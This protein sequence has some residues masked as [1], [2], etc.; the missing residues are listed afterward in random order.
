VSARTILHMRPLDEIAAGVV[1]GAPTALAVARSSMTAVVNGESG[2]ERLNAFI[3]FDYEAAVEQ[4]RRIDARVRAGETMA[5]AGVPVAVKDNIC[6]LGLPTTCGSRAL[7]DYW[8]PYEATAVKRLREAGA[9]IVGK[10]NLDEFAMGSSTEYSALGPTRNPHDPARVAGG[11]SGGSAAAVAADLVPA[12]LGSET[13]G[14]VRLPAA[15]CGVV[16]IKPSYGLVSR[17]GLVAHASSLDQVGVCAVTVRDAARLLEVIAGP[18]PFDASCRATAAHALV[19]AGTM[20]DDAGTPLRGVVVGL[21]QEYLPPSLDAGVRAAFDGAVERLRSLGAEVRPV[22]LPH[23]RYAVPAYCVIATAEASSNLARFDGV[24]YGLRPRDANT[25][26]AVFEQSRSV[27]FGREV[28]RRIMLG[29]FVLS[30]G[31]H[32]E[33]YGTA[34]RVRTLVAR[35]FD[36][37][38]GKVDVLFTPTAPSGAFRIGE[39]TA[40]PFDMYLSD[41]FTVS[42]N[43]AALPA[44]SLPIGTSAGLPVGGQVIAARWGE[45]GM[46]R[47]AAALERALQA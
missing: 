47:I 19:D 8:S 36:R 42:A 7:A 37:V 34:Q 10:T 26:S 9:V 14:S 16:G 4:A 38:F 20:N 45:A 43:L 25:A 5:L 12:A 17:Y 28:K 24:Q 35:D 40:D 23:S 33:Y 44:L 39:R 41:I 3:S 2:P 1:A 27:G 46:V 29:T 22:S 15:F 11:S 18:D 21:P 30:E 6:T 32:D 31:Y 13:G